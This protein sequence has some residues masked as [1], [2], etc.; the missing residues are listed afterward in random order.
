MITRQEIGA[1]IL[2]VTL[3]V[4]LLFHGIIKFQSGMV[5]QYWF[6]RIYGIRSSF[7]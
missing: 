3:A 5:R 6:T 7:A 1:F 4:I 2:R